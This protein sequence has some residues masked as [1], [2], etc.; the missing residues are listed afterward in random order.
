[1]S[2]VGTWSRT[3][4][5][6]GI[7]SRIAAD[8]AR[9]FAADSRYALDPLA[10]LDDG[11]V[12]MAGIADLGEDAD[13]YE[14]EGDGEDELV[15]VRFKPVLFRPF[16]H[17]RETI[18]SWIDLDHLRRTAAT[19]EPE[20]RFRNLLDEKSRQMGE[21]WT[22]SWAL[23]WALMYYPASAG[24]AVHQNG[25]KVDDGGNSST[26]E[27]IFGRIRYMAE[28]RLRD[29]STTW[30]D[31]HYPRDLLRF[32]GSNGPGTIVNRL[33]GA[34]L[35]GATATEDPGRGG[36]YTH[37]LVD[38][39]ARLPWGR[40]AQAALRSACPRGRAY[41]STPNGEDNLFYDLGHPRRRGYVY[42]RHHWSAHPIYGRGLHVAG[43]LD[44]CRLCDGNRAGIEW[45]ATAPRAHRYPGRVTSPWYDDAVLDL[46]DEQVAAEL[47]IS[48]ERSLEARVYPQFSEETHVLPEIPA[49]T[50]AS[51]EL[52]FDFGIDTT[53]VGIWQELPAGW[54]DGQPAIWAKIG[55]VEAHDSTPEEV[56]TAIREELADLGFP[57]AAIR[58]T[59]TREYL[60]VGDPAGNAR[61]L[62]GS[63]IPD[64]AA[65][66]F[67]IA[68]QRN[69][70]ART[71]WALQRLLQGRPLPVRYSAATTPETIAHIKANRW[72]TDRHGN[73]KVG[74]TEPLNDRHNHMM[75]ADAYLAAWKYPPPEL[76]EGPGSAFHVDELL[77]YQRL[78]S[79]D[80]AA[81]DDPDPYGGVM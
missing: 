23:L 6:A 66:G 50:Q 12:L 75:R 43:E 65:Q 48:Y 63:W 4:R 73:R 26:P 16:E 68:T 10:H 32:R 67:S 49:N 13:E 17:E 25:R 71:V 42:L 72:P 60:A 79:W 28:S 55:E 21:T 27:S 57:L 64:L 35:T 81:A 2:P 58:P 39:A 44:G 8:A 40:Q 33:S 34:R 5:R 47:D 56:A 77:P 14:V 3:I 24:L 9:G 45:D 15:T 20:L 31:S 46:T 38:E 22:F 54:V 19:G 18:E 80:D 69:T 1:M 41:V 52:S 76:D 74:V 7:G 11:H 36:T 37:V 53:A 78:G 59:V 70:I 62:G 29:G 30:P 61:E 51:V